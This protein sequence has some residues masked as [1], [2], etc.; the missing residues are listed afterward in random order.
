[1]GQLNTCKCFA[2]AGCAC[3]QSPKMRIKG[4]EK[5]QFHEG[6]YNERVSVGDCGSSGTLVREQCV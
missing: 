4:L 2:C 5:A 3:L 1:M 6:T